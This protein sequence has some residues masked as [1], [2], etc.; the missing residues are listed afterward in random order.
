VLIG[1]SA[2]HDSPPT[3]NTHTKLAFLR[4]RD[5]PVEWA[6]LNGVYVLDP[7]GYGP[8]ENLLYAQERVEIY[9]CLT[10]LTISSLTFLYR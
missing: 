3:K 4:A 1:I 10:L 5:R 9:L 2:L 8:R 7:F 6:M